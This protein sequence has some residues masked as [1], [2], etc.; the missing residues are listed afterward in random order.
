M[1]LPSSDLAISKSATPFRV[2]LL[3]WLILSALSVLFA[4]VTS[5]SSRF[6]FFTPWGLLVVLP[7]YGLHVLVL[8]RPYLP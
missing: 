4:E 1:E 2:N 8:W 7:L 3:F 5:F 6:G